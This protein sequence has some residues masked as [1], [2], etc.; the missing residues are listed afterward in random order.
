M[1]FAVSED[2]MGEF[3]PARDVIRDGLKAGVFER[4]N[5]C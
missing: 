2:G 3:F 1:A 5:R 4:G